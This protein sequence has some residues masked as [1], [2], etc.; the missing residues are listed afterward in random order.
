MTND[1]D[2]YP[3]TPHQRGVPGKPRR[4]EHG[5][6]L[7]ATPI[8][9]VRD[10]TLRAMDVL[11]QADVLAAEDTR[12]T[13]KLLDILGIRREERGIIPYHDHNGAAQRPRLLRELAAG[14]SVAL[15]SDAGTPMVADPGFG[16][17]RE[18]IAA[19]HRVLAAPGA[20]AVL[21][22][23]CV[24]GLPTDRFLFNGFL[25]P[26]S[27]ARGKALEALKSVPA[28]LVFYEGP[29]RVSACLA[30]MRDVLGGA[31]QA[32][33]CRELTKKFEETR[34]GTLEELAE[35]YSSEGAPKGEVVILIGPP[36]EEEA[37]EKDV[38]ASLTKAL[39]TM[40]VKDAAGEVALRFGM[41]RREIYARALQLSKRE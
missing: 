1:D 10:I 35:W 13:R 4:P 16:L 31:R 5:L 29:K 38:D 8:G 36:V 27:V 34:R 37:D 14:K 23:L 40:S 28:T 2:G 25:P 3:E 20:S 32:V 11:E 18:V 21:S 7:V 9:N 26:K 39:E 22:A 41:P 15:V 33:V 12:Q 19:G 30:A 24:S 6:H 17:V